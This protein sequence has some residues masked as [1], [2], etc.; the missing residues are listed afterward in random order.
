[1]PR[2]PR[3]SRFGFADHSKHGSQGGSSMGRPSRDAAKADRKGW[4][5][6]DE[7]GGFFGRRH[8]RRTSPGE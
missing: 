2:T 3:G 1:M 4:K 8:Q 7:T 6:D 5:S